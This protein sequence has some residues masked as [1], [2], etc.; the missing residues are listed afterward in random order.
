MER[1]P[2]PPATSL[3]NKGWSAL[4]TLRSNENDRGAGASLSK[5]AQTEETRSCG[6]YRDWAK[7]RST[8]DLVLS[9][10]CGAVRGKSAWTG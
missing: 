8:V 6:V 5:I 9:C 7:G 3:G 2:R 4:E 10:S 1:F